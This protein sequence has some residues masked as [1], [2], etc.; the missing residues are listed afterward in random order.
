VFALVNIN[1]DKI[2]SSLRWIV[3]MIFVNMRQI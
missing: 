3:N 1:H 2:L